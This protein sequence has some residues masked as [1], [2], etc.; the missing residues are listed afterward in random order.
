MQQ[1]VENKPSV[2]SPP[3]LCLFIPTFRVAHSVLDVLRGID[4]ATLRKIHTVLL[5]DNGSDDGTLPI[6]E[7]FVREDRSGKFRLFLNRKNYSLGGSTILAFRI[8]QTMGCDFVICMHSDG[9]ADPADLEKLIAASQPGVDFVF[10]SRLLKNSQVEA[11]SR[12][13]RLGNLFFAQLQR[14]ITGCDLAD[15][16]AFISFNLQTVFSLP[17]DQLA[18]DMGYQPLLV[19]TAF[20]RL[21]RIHY[22]EL[23]IRWNRVT[24][25]NVNVWVYGLKHLLRILT[26]GFG[27]PRLRERP[28]DFFMTKEWIAAGLEML[29]GP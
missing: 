5:I 15:I 9:Q 4:T 11:Y 8:A 6:L 25:S 24:T 1:F 3:K 21:P 10:G 16:G 20:H 14:F 23:P 28:G 18:F 13:R 27:R 12:L 26:M 7:Q 17:F 19:L 22:V 29:V 2:K